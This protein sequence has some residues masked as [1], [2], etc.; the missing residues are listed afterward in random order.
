[1]KANADLN[2]DG[3]ENPR[4]EARRKS[5][6][7]APS[8]KAP[9]LLSSCWKVQDRDV[10]VVSRG[11]AIVGAA[12][13]S[14][15]G[16]AMGLATIDGKPVRSTI[17]GGTVIGLDGYVREAKVPCGW[18]CHSTTLDKQAPSHRTSMSPVVRRQ[19]TLTVAFT[20]PC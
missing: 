7:T 20:S 17:E 11:R 13:V 10:P 14:I 15:I 3:A 2:G 5:D 9:T 6:L 16:R 4:A 8:E 12:T 1:M 19:H 18:E